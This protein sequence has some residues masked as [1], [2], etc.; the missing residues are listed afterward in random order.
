MTVE[1]V[2]NMCFWQASKWKKSISQAPYTAV[3]AQT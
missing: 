2:V 3:I 1:Q